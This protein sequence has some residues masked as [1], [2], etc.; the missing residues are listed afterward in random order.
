MRKIYL[1]CLFAFV[2][3]SVLSLVSC[4]KSSDDSSSSQ[5][6]S[7]V[8]KWDLKAQMKGTT[9]IPLSAC[10]EQYNQYQFLENLTYIVDW[11]YTNNGTQCTHYTKT[12]TYSLSNDILITNSFD[13]I[14]YQE[15]HSKILELTST[16]LKVK[17]FYRKEKQG[18]A[19]TEINIPEEQQGIGIFEKIN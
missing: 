15:S 16:K 10:E 5:F 12:N 3:I 17:T 14:I 8:G 4:S 1:T 13:G 19:I 7:I 6:S 2:S 18:T 11:G 9:S